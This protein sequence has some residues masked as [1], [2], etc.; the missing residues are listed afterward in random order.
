LS[1]SVLEIKDVGKL[2]V[3]PVCPDVKTALGFN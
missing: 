3:E 1:H 2:T